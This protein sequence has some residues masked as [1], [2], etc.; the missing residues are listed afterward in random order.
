[1]QTVII[2]RYMPARETW[3]ACRKDLI[4]LSMSFIHVLRSFTLRAMDHVKQACVASMMAIRASLEGCRR[5]ISLCG[6]SPNFISTYDIQRLF[7]SLSYRQ[8]RSTLQ[9]K[10]VAEFRKGRQT[11]ESADFNRVSHSIYWIRLNCLTWYQGV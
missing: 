1:V 2:S 7:V 5:C 10:I 4:K 9:T 3:A 11:K 6:L 8:T